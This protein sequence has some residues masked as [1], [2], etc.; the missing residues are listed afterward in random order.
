M[1]VYNTCRDAVHHDGI[2]VGHSTQLV[3]VVQKVDFLRGSPGSDI[4]T[5]FRHGLDRLDPLIHVR[6]LGIQEIAVIQEL[7]R[8][9]IDGGSCGFRLS[10]FNGLLDYGVDDR[11]R[12]WNLDVLLKV[13]VF[14]G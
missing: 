3:H 6:T 1:P 9:V 10:L 14:P 8:N 7:R 11:V 2:P 12:F 13:K 5:Q 4:Y